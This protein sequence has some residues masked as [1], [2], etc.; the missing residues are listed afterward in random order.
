MKDFNYRLQ[1]FP[2][3]VKNRNKSISMLFTS[4]EEL[5]AAEMMASQLLLFLQDDIKAM[6]YCSN[7]FIA[8]EF[9]RE[10]EEWDILD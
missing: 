8:Y 2:D 10:S 4:I 7:N 6:N 5:N 9:D 3:I 1:V